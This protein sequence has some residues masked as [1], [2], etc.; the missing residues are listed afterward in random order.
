MESGTFHYL[1]DNMGRMRD[2]EH[3]TGLRLFEKAPTT[4]RLRLLTH[5]SVGLWDWMSWLDTFGTD[6]ECPDL[7][8]PQ[9]PAWYVTICIKSDLCLWGLKC[10][11]K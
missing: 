3:L 7:Q 4:D 8:T 9:C 11:T 2:V 1:Q 10:C 6:E 5:M